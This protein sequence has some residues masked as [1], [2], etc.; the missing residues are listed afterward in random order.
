MATPPN[1]PSAAIKAARDAHHRLII[2]TPGGG[3]WGW[4]LRP[5]TP[6]LHLLSYTTDPRRP[7]IVWLEDSAGR[8]TVEP[9]RRVLVPGAVLEAVV[10]RLAEDG[11]RAVVEE[12][13]LSD[14]LNVWGWVSTENT[15]MCWVVR[16]YGGTSNVRD[17]P[18]TVTDGNLV[19]PDLIAHAIIDAGPP[20]AVV[21]TMLDGEF[22]HVP[23]RGLLWRG[24]R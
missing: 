11:E 14:A 6:R 23:L 17:I 7:L 1:K 5:P 21:T 13:W 20:V 16:M 4:R 22:N 19:R 24:A 10:W 18:L 12:Q 9:D 3:L 15:G 8:R 2:D